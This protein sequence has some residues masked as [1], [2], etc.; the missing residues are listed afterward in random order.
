MDNARLMKVKHELI[1]TMATPGWRSL[2]DRAEAVIRQMSSTAID[3]E[4]KAKSETLV[5]E[6]RAAKKFWNSLVGSVTASTVVDGPDD[7][8]GDDFYE[9]AME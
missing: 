6:A 7:S 2:I 4:D 1:Q 8:N 3:C 9:V 5:T